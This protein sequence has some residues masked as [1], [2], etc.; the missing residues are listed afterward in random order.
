MQLF[1][2]VCKWPIILFS[3]YYLHEGFCLMIHKFFLLPPLSLPR[4]LIN[5]FETPAMALVTLCHA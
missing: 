2:L 3:V 5:V 1:F 4:G